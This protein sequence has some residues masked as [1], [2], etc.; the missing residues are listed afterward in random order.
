[1]EVAGTLPRNFSRLERMSD[2]YLDNNHLT[3]AIPREWTRMGLLAD[4]LDL[5]ARRTHAHMPLTPSS[6][7]ARRSLVFVD[8]LWITGLSSS[9]LVSPIVLCTREVLLHA[10]ITAVC[11]CFSCGV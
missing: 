3:G 11:C 2:L 1:M 6:L 9:H 5:C 4:D 8:G 7:S 10:S